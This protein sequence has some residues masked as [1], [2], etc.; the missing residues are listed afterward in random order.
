MP[1]VTHCKCGRQ[2][3]VKDELAGKRVRCPACSEVVQVPAAE[4]EIM[5]VE[6][7]EEAPQRRPSRPPD[8]EPV[9]DD[10]PRDV[11]E[12]RLT[13]GADSPTPFW[14]NGDDL[15]AVAEDAFYQITLTDKKRRKAQAELQEGRPAAEVLEGAGTV[16]LWDIVTKIEGNLH[17]TFF[18]IKHRAPKASEE[19]EHTVHCADAASRDEMLKAIRRRLGPDWKREVK[20]YSRLRASVEPLIVIVFFTFIT[21]CFYMAGRGEDSSNGSKTI[22]TNWLGM[23]FVWVYNL[24]GPWGV[25]ALGGLIIALGIAWL[26]ARML[27]PPLMCTISPRQALPR[28]K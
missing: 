8:V 6:P 1:I 20:E 19:E 7:A 13:E 28:R 22:R 9:E 11:G 26:V 23:I 17:H 27:K 18:D 5:E 16:I 2:L 14:I 10:Q 25:V 24:L 21:F 3:R 12:P 4:E 15:L